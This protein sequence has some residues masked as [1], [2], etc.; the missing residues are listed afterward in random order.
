[1]FASFSATVRIAIGRTFTPNLNNPPF[2]CDLPVS[3]ENDEMIIH[4]DVLNVWRENTIIELIENNVANLRKLNAIKIEW[5]RFDVSSIIA[6]CESITHKLLS[7]GIDHYA[8]EFNGNHG[9][10]KFT[11]DGRYLADML[12]FLARSLHFE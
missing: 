3:F 5:G 4:D 10:D 2:Y 11:D 9:I 8:E 7:Y 6:S 1:M 12:P